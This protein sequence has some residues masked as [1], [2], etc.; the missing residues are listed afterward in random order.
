MR[1]EKLPR[2]RITSLFRGCNFKTK[3]SIR[4][5]GNGVL[6]RLISWVFENMVLR[7]IFAPRRDEVRGDGGDCVTRS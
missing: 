3:A 5:D 1:L 2:A 4:T 6:M 7:R